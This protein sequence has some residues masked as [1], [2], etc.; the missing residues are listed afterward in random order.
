MKGTIKRIAVV[1]AGPSGLCCAKNALDSGHDVVVYELNSTIGGLWVYTD[2]IGY[3]E[4]GIPIHSTMFKGIVWVVFRFI[5]IFI[6]KKKQ[7][8]G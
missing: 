7:I 2:Q 6:R 1:G 8:F 4:F 3:D 5:Q